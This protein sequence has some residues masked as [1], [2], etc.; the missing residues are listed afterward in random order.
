MKRINKTHT[1]SASLLLAYLSKVLEIYYLAM[2]V[3]RIICAR[4]C[5][6]I[7]NSQ[8]ALGAV[9]L[10]S[11]LAELLDLYLLNLGVNIKPSRWGYV[12]HPSIT[13]R[14]ALDH[15]LMTKRLEFSLDKVGKVGYY[16]RCG[17][18]STS[19][20]CISTEKLKTENLDLVVWG[21]NLGS[22]VGEGKLTKQIKSMIT[23]PPF[24]KSVVVGLLLSDG[25]LIFP[26]GA[27][28]N[29]R[30]CLEQSYSHK[31]YVY[32]VFFIFI[33]LL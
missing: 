11:A 29:V 13:R 16:R 14:L 27:S 28:K 1:R 17:F 23:L 32:Y 4:F 26:R 10:V 19:K 12:M 24:Y 22:T 33:A 30:L 18:Y 21:T 25:W 5:L 8:L 20:A 6:N 9:F 7:S 31:A 2:T 15:V 3:T